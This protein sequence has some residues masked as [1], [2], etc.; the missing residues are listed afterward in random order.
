MYQNNRIKW[1]SR[2]DP[3]YVIF[4]YETGLSQQYQDRS[5]NQF[6]RL[7]YGPTSGYDFSSNLTGRTTFKHPPTVEQIVAQGYFSVPKSEPETAII[8]DKK[9][10][11]W[12]GLDDIIGQ[13]RHRYEIYQSTLYD[14]ELS[15]CAAINSL[16]THE[17]WRGPS[18]SKL[19]Y[20]VSKRVDRLYLEQREERV[21]LW[22][23]VS[24]LKLLLPESV[25]LYLA[26]YRKV[27]I[28]QDSGGDGP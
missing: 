8:S 16:Y 6:T 12:L 17:A 22:K 24:K 18:D 7:N 13:I 9:H 11:S 10:T 20:S 14:L 27:S 15:K 28:L 23:D 4:F 19:E 5:K 25:Q 3:E 2:T 21:N 26:S 1:P